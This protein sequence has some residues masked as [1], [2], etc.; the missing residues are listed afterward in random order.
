MNDGSILSSLHEEG[1]SRLYAAVPRLSVG[2]ATCGVAAGALAVFEAFAREIGNSGK[3]LL[4]RVGCRGMCWAEPLVEIQ[5][6]GRPRAIYGHMSSQRASELLKAAEDGHLPEEGLLGF[7]YHD[8]YP[9]TGEERTLA[10]GVVGDF[11]LRPDQ[12]CQ[13]RHV[14]GECGRIAPTSV[15][16]YVAMGG[17]GALAKV[18]R[19]GS[20]GKVI[21]ELEESGLR[22]R[23]GAGY[24]TGRKWRATREGEPGPRYFVANG[25]EGDPGAYMDRSLLESAPHRI[26]EGLAIGSYA[27]G[28][29][30]AYVFIRSEYPLAVRILEESISAATADGLLGDNILD[31]GY[32]LHVSIVRS[33]GAFVCGEESSLIRALEGKTPEPQ[34]RPPFPS[35]RGLFGR[36]TCINNVETLANVPFIISRGAAAFRGLG[37]SDSPGTKVFSLTGAVERAGLIEVELG[38]SIADIFESIGGAANTKAIQIGGPSG[39]LLSAEALDLPIDYE[40]L[41]AAGGIMGS[42]GLV[43]LTG[44]QCVVDTVRYLLDFS[45]NESCGKC[46]SCREGLS[47]CAEILER[48][49]EGEGSEQ[50]IVRLQTLST[51]VEQTSMC[52]LGENGHSPA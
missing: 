46:T 11:R 25:D 26:L 34:P 41:A 36:P 4:V 1:D 48:I 33:A 3:A 31:S 35:E 23:G 28:V 6:P 40:S 32:S 44:D 45:A 27:L 21:T 12:A 10:G 50:D 43:V 39:A 14:M 15:A 52:G 19:E 8:S 22:G 24:P 42:G 29:E 51:Y 7:V 38:T 17:Y 30:Q 13:V 20:P 18:L 2:T 16:E 37:T 47:E 9:L 5:L 49:C